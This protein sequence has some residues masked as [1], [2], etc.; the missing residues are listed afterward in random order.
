M[1]KKKEKG[2][3]LWW[4]GGGRNLAQSGTGARA[5]TSAPAQPR[6]TARNSAGA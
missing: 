5:G 3:W 4:A 2:F 1:E 6:P